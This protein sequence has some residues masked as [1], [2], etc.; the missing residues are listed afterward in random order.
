[1]T[2]RLVRGLANLRSK[3]PFAVLRR[4]FAAAKERLNMR[5]IHFSVQGN[6][7]HLI[8]EASDRTALGRAMRGLQIRMARGLN[9]LFGRMGRVF[10]D[11]YHARVMKTPR[12]TRNGIAYVLLN[13]RRH[14][15]QRGLDHRNDRIDPCPSGLG[16]DGWTT[17]IDPS[18]AIPVARPE[19]WLL[20]V[21]WRRRGLSRRQRFLPRPEVGRRDGSESLAIDQA[22]S[23]PRRHSSAQE[24]A[25][26]VTRD[27]AKALREGTRA[28]EAERVVTAEREPAEKAGSI[29]P[30][31]REPASKAVLGHRTSGVGVWFGLGLRHGI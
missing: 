17:P 12:E 11:R 5:L 25:E 16:F 3:K 18:E 23:S 15:Y 30:F 20:R 22:R 21:G 7:L 8:V 9:R 26:A 28:E 13:S 29:M 1:V 14:A 6:H 2:L 19:C 4:S 27:D 24:E 10:A 31:V